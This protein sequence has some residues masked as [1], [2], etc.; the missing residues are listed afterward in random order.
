MYVLFIIII[1]YNKKAFLSF[2]Y[3]L[4]FTCVFLLCYVLAFFVLNLKIFSFYGIFS[5]VHNLKS[6]LLFSKIG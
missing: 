5:Y 2:L 6:K 1:Y 3:P 4:L